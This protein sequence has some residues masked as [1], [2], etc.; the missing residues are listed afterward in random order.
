MLWT[1]GPRGVRLVTQVVAGKAAD[2]PLYMP[3]IQQV[4][5]SLP[6]HGVLYVGDCKMA[7]LSTRAYV[8]AQGDYYLCPLAQ[9]QLPP[10]ELDRYLQPVW[11]GEQ[12]L[13]AVHRAKTEE[14][15][16][17][18][19]QG[20]EQSVVCRCEVAGQ[21]LNSTERQVIVRAGKRTRTATAALHASMSN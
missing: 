12:P 3:S 6:E 15:D 18:L 7:A 14:E 11:S 19:A 17:L 16:E 8:Q 4:S 5:Q 2:D 9:T 10:Q 20:L 21:A 13:V 1:L